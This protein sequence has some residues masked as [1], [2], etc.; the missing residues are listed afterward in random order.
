MGKGKIENELAF[1]F[2]GFSF[3]MML[4]L[5]DGICNVLF[6]FERKERIFE[7]K[8]IFPDFIIREWKRISISLN[9]QA[10]HPSVLP[11]FKNVV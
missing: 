4:P 3:A 7:W 2:G 9:Y 11:R 5:D 8:D 6:N 10:S 1:L